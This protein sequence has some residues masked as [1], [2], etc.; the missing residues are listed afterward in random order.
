MTPRISVLLPLT[1]EREAGVEAVHAWL[2]QSVDPEVFE[3]LALAP[4][5]DPELERAVVPLLRGRDRCV[6]HRGFDEYE[7]FNLGARDA[8]GDF[9]VLTEAHCVP[10]RNFLDEMLAELDRTGAPAIRNASMP[11]T[12]GRFGALELSQVDAATR[13]EEDPSHWRKVL[14]HGFGIRREIFLAAGGFPARY[15]DFSPWALSIALWERGERSAYSDRPRATHVY[16]GDLQKLGPYVRNF[17]RGEMRFWREQPGRAARFLDWPTEW[18]EPAQYSRAGAVRAIR[19]AVALRHGSSGRELVGHLAVAAFGVRAAILATAARC[20]LATISLRLT[21]DQD[22]RRRRFLAFWRLERR[23]GSLEALAPPHRG[24]SPAAV[25]APFD[26][27]GSSESVIGAH[28]PERL[29]GESPIRWTTPLCLLRVNVPGAGR[30]RA[31]IGLRAVERPPGAP[32]NPR[33]AVDC[34]PVT[35]AFSDD[36][37]EFDLDAGERWVAIASDP[38]APR[39]WGVE[40]SRRLGLPLQSISFEP[41]A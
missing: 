27:A 1:D 20:K 12:R 22:R 29:D 31:R 36:A 38:W 21:R 5:D 7:L 32:A 34:R 35:A 23:R 19:A 4:G 3:I 8:R 15:G 26:L 11:D 24:A 18:P 33:I 41:A 17:S 30:M 9:L 37:I 10:E 14:I 2:E 28:A 16:D 6:I 13:A 40:D 25:S 39:K